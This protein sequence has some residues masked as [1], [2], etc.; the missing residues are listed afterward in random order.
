VDVRVGL[1]A[2]FLLSRRAAAREPILLPRVSTS[3]AVCGQSPL[4]GTP[5]PADRPRSART[6][7]AVADGRHAPQRPH[8]HPRHGTGASENVGVLSAQRLSAT[9]AFCSASV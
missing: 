2:N 6:P 9:R 5:C 7:L 3:A 8:I 1:G 4:Y